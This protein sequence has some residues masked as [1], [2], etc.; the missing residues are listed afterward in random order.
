MLS[1]LTLEIYL[2]FDMNY[3]MKFKELVQEEFVNDVNKK[4]KLDNVLIKGEEGIIYS[5]TSS[6]SRLIY[7]C[8]YE[9]DPLA[10][11]NFHGYDLELV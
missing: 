5:V 11:Y 2:E 9:N 7:T 10:L 6:G 3:A 1:D 4:L 8:F